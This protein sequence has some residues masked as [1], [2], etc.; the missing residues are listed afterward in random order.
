MPRV[1]VTA[2]TILALS[3]PAAYAAD[4]ATGTVSKSATTVKWTGQSDFGATH[5]FPWIFTNVVGDSPSPCQAPSCDTFTLTVAESGD[6]TID[7]TSDTSTITCVEIVKPDG[8]W[9]YNS[10]NDDDSNTTTT[11]IKRAK[12]GEYSVH[13][14]INAVDF[15][16]YSGTATLN[17]PPPP[18]PVVPDT[19]AAAAPTTPATAQPP[20]AP[21]AP[22]VS[23]AATKVSAR[24]AKRRLSVALSSTGPVA[25][26]RVVLRKGSKVVATGTLL[27]LDGKGKLTL[28]LKK[29]LKAGSYSIAVSVPGGAG[30]VA[31][32]KV[33]R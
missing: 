16:D 11:T 4:P 26:V 12:P 7:V 30:A 24:K 2:L 23:V 15:A 3:S 27:E 5:T 21:A 22:S 28:K 8:S 6:L 20:A 25:N 1:L 14:A 32:L 33:T 9:V 10:G 29:A 13:V 19:P 18:K 17:F 31:P